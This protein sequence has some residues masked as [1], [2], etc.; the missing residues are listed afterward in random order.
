MQLEKDFLFYLFFFH[1]YQYQQ[2]NIVH[3]FAQS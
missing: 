1:K 2:V 3:V